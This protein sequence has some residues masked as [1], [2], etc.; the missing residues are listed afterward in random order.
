MSWMPPQV[1]SSY[2]RTRSWASLRSALCL[3][4]FAW[5]VACSSHTGTISS[6]VPDQRREA[7]EYATRARRNY[8]PPGPPEDPWRPYIAEAS[9]RFD[10]PERWIRE[11]MRVE[12]GGKQYV[13]GQLITSPK[14]AM[15]LM[16]VMPMTYDLMRAHYG[17]GDDPYDPRNNILAGTA[18]IREMY[19]LYGS[20]AF[21]AA[22]NAGPGRVDDYMQ[23]SRPLPEE[24]RRYIA[25]IAP[26]IQEA[27]PQNRSSADQL[28]MNLPGSLDDITVP[29]FPHNPRGYESPAIV[30][31]QHRAGIHPRVARLHS[32][33]YAALAASRHHGSRGGHS[34]RV[35]RAEHSRRYARAHGSH[36][37]AYAEARAHHGVHA[38]VQYV[39]MR[40]PARPAHHGRHAVHHTQNAPRFQLA[41]AAAPVASFRLVSEA[42]AETRTGHRRSSHGTAH[43]VTPHRHER[44]RAVPAALHRSGAHRGYASRRS[45]HARHRSRNRLASAK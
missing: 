18:Y 1:F 30:M 43:H 12:S 3:L 6:Q 32:A 44:A 36:G 24:T 10:V 13:N 28:A 35:A 5:L 39:A 26:Y 7:E 22:Y 45:K 9:Q 42:M 17:L 21:L 8:E 33:R 27:Y 23:H 31:A 14:G 2:A 15:G 19:D 4:A 20:P 41:M 11:V 25:M 38:R 37:R 40:T 34:V 16:Q 29:H